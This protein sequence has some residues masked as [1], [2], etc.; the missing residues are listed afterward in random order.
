MTAVSFQN[1]STPSLRAC[2]GRWRLSRSSLFP[3]SNHYGFS[4]RT[5]LKSLTNVR[6]HTLSI[7]RCKSFRLSVYYFTQ[8]PRSI[9]ILY[10]KFS[11]SMLVRIHSHHYHSING[12]WTLWSWSCW[13]YK[14]LLN[15]TRQVPRQIGG[16]HFISGESDSIV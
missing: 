6:T 3:I 7:P 10:Y 14:K 11:P 2:G 5:F 16:T 13:I 12:V 4:T 15:K 8:T 1:Y 9:M